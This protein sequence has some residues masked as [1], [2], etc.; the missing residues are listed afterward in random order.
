[1]YTRDGWTCEPHT[2]CQPDVELAALHLEE[3]LMPIPFAQVCQCG[4]QKTRHHAVLVCL[5]HCD[6]ACRVPYCTLCKLVAVKL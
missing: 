3:K 5:T 4:A 2:P 6:Q 1:M